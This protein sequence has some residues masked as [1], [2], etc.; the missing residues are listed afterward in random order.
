MNEQG[1]EKLIIKLK[2]QEEKFESYKGF[3]MSWLAFQFDEIDSPI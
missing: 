3:I 2:R 1:K